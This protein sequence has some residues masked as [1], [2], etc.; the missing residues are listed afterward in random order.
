M[1]NPAGQGNAGSWA[2]L[3]KRGC[4][5]ATAEFPVPSHQLGTAGVGMGQAGASED[6]KVSCC[7]PA[8]LLVMTEIPR[9]SY[10][11]IFPRAKDNEYLFCTDWY[12]KYKAQKAKYHR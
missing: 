6:R 9:D 5:E 12:L 3:G 10:M 7:V 8:Q 2:L 4:P 1:L 11:P